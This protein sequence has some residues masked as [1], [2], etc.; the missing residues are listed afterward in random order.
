MAKNFYE[1]AKSGGKVV[2]R[3]AKDGKKIK[4]CYDDKGKGH[5]KPDKNKN[6]NKKFNNS[7]KPVEASLESLKKLADHFNSVR[8]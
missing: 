5:V 6:K 3:K 7:K 4:V 2:T 8:Y 1:C